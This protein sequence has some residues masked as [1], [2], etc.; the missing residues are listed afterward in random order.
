MRSRSALAVLAFFLLCS[1]LALASRPPQEWTPPPEMTP[2]QIEAQKIAMRQKFNSY[3]N[4]VS[5]KATPVPWGA[6]G[7]AALA[8][9]VATP[10]A[11]RAYRNTA[12]DM[13]VSEGYATDLDE[14]V[15]RS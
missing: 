11:L 8:F 15:D 1:T 9:I 6:I 5:E 14:P 7:M 10:F 4:D 12:Q 13:N 3:G 2:E